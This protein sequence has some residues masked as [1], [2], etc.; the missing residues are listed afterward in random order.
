MYCHETMLSHFLLGDTPYL[1]RLSLS[2]GG[3]KSRPVD[4]ARLRVIP[5][6]YARYDQF[7]SC[8]SQESAHCSRPS[9]AWVARCAVKA[10]LAWHGLVTRRKY[11]EKRDRISL[12]AFTDIAAKY[13]WQQS[14]SK[15]F[16]PSQTIDLYSYSLAWSIIY[17][18]STSRNSLRKVSF[19]T[20]DLIHKILHNRYAWKVSSMQNPF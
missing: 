3:F 8:A 19:E 13:L 18:H 15:R 16:C 12:A 10:H 1:L 7:P 9:I 20:I 14:T 2:L 5:L 17:T 6:V 11:K 4:C